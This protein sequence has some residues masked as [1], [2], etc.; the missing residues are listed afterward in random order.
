MSKKLRTQRNFGKLQSRQPI[1]NQRIEWLREFRE[2][3]N[4]QSFNKLVLSF[5]NMILKS[6]HKMSRIFRGAQVHFDDLVQVGF[7]A[8]IKGIRTLKTEE[9]LT[10]YCALLIKSA[11]WKFAKKINIVDLKLDS[12]SRST[13]KKLIFKISTLLDLLETRDTQEKEYKRKEFS[14]RINVPIEDIIEAEVRLSMTVT[15]IDDEITPYQTESDIANSID[16]KLMIREIH[17]AVNQLE[18]K[19]RVVIEERFFADEPKT[20]KQL[21]KELGCDKLTV[22]ARRKSGIK[23]LHKIFRNNQVIREMVSDV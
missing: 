22:N 17:K 3:N 13:G 11:Q 15:Q 4:E 8:I 7:E 2:Y 20:L 18:E 6:A 14:N 19:Y 5:K 12:I 21:G 16:Y 10:G 23:Q 1:D 9:Y